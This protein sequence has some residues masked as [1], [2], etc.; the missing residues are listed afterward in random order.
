[1]PQRTAEDEL[2]L[3]AGF[4]GEG[5]QISPRGN[6]PRGRPAKRGKTTLR[7]PLPIGEVKCTAS[8]GKVELQLNRDF[9]TISR[10]RLEAAVEA[11]FAALE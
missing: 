3:L 6:A 8:A 5:L 10:A 1:M 9:S 2:A 4:A 11:F 7:L